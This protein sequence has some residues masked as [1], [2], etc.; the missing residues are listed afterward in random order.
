MSDASSGDPRA[1][2]PDRA[3]HDLVVANARCV[4]TVDDQRRELHGGWVAITDGLVS[5]VGDGEAPAAR[6][7]LDATD[8]LVTP[9]LV[10]T[11]H[12]LYQNLTRAYPP[13]TDKPLF[14][15]LQSLY[16]LWRSIDT[17]SV[18]TSAWVGLA[19]LALSGCTTSTDHLYVHPRGA[20]DLL[21]AEIDAARDLGIRFHPTRGSMSLSEKDGG[22]PPDDVV[23]DDDEILAAC[24]E[25]VAR[26]HD[27]SFGAMTRVALAPCSPFS[28]TEDL[29][30]RT[31]ELAERLDVRLH[32]HFAE[33]AEDD[34]FSL[35]TFGCRPMEYL[36]RT[37]W[38]TDRTWVAHCVMP[39]DDE[40]ARLGAA[41]IGA[42]H[43]PS[44]NLILASGISPVVSLRAAGVKVGIGVDGSSSADSASMWLEARQAMLLAKLRDGASAG[45]ARM[46]LEMA[47]IGGA[48]CLGREGEIGTLQVGAVAD[49]AVWSLTGPSFAGA[50][51]DPIE[52]WLRCGPS[53]ARDTIVAGRAIVRNGELVTDR[54]EEMLRLH[55]V[56][57]S[58]IQQLD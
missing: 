8:C 50:I 54:L 13:M 26:H 23:A 41:G 12:H 43:C 39:N 32:T 31:A 17:E 7:R 36:E 55:A 52:A 33:N 16:P 15:W 28:V 22:L 21:T 47:T 11:H 29:M 10:N 4:A 5:G 6:E 34:E 57:A 58:K 24:E 51:A 27:R 44:S 49:V 19:E 56:L 53:A 37:G 9:G 1:S 35:A 40:V 46:A 38:C 42:A 2:G 25:A 20:G 14:G 18:Y 45:T 48:G 30:V 3:V